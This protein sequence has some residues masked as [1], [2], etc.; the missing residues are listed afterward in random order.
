MVPAVFAMDGENDCCSGD[1][2]KA[3][4]FIESVTRDVQSAVAQLLSTLEHVKREIASCDD[5][6]PREPPG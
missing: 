6:T 4:R 2:L 5:Q 1:Q 3:L